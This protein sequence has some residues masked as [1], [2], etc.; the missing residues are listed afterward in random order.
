LGM[1][2]EAEEA[3]RES[4]GCAGGIWVDDRCWPLGGHDDA[5][6][7]EESTWDRRGVVH[8]GMGEVA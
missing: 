2:G 6:A 8:D 1:L 3:V 5:G 7:G 4:A